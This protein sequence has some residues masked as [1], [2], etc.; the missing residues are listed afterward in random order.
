MT[1]NPQVI[2]GPPAL[3]PTV[4]LTRTQGSPASNSQIGTVSDDVA[5]PGSISVT[6][7][8]AP[9]G[10]TVT[11]IM[12]TNGTITANIEAGCSAATG[13]NTIVLLATD[14]KALSQTANLVINVAANTAPTLGNYSNTSIVV[15]CKATI[16]PT[17]TPGDN[18]SVSTVTAT[19][20]AGFTGTIMV[21]ATTGVVTITNSGPVGPAT[22]TVTAT[23]N[24]G[25]TNSKQFTLTVVNPPTAPTEFDFDGDR[26]ADVSV[27]RPGATANDFS[28][29]FILRSSD[30]TVQ[31][32]QFGHDTDV[33]VPGDYNGD[34]TTDVAIYRPS[35]NTWFT[36]TDPATNYGAFQWGSAGD[37][38]VPGIYDADNKTDIA[39]FRPSTGQWFISK[40]TGGSDAIN[41]GQS[42]DKP[43]PADYDGDGKTDE[44]VYRPSEG[45]W[46]IRKSSG[47]TMQQNWG[48]ASDFLVPA[49]YDGDGKDDIAVFRP[50]TGIWYIISSS[51]GTRADQWG[52]SGDTP[53]AA[54][55]D[56]DG[57]ADLSVYRPSEGSWF[58]FSSCPCVL[59]GK[60]FGIATD[61]PIPSA[62]TPPTGP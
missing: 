60:Q 23:D 29:W 20:S 6:V 16:T 17:A 54:D 25:L 2:T 46:Y 30:S 36:S 56:N 58:I 21:D 32:I 11:N 4:G 41:W 47:G 55:Y 50:S 27:Y 13:D 52:Q 42:G 22:I 48:V 45:N 8:S 44:A 43:V 14:G 3:A 7:Q 57:K 10:I 37:I 39:V 31:Y 62:F 53:V 61:K 35:I 5:S 38:P 9:T 40:S 18:G 49:D 33:I 24:C 51:G 1:G 34:G 59:N 26:K 19:G 15:S 12:N 28:F